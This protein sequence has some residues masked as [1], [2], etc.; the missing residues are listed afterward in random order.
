MTPETLP[1]LPASTFTVHKMVFIRRGE[2]ATTPRDPLCLLDSEEGK[3]V[4]LS[5]EDNFCISYDDDGLVKAQVYSVEEVTLPSWLSPE[6]WLASHSNWHFHWA[7]GMDP[8]WPE[9][10]QRGLMTLSALACY[11]LSGLIRATPR[12]DFKASLK[13]QLT[14]WLDLKPELREFQHPLSMRQM[15]CLYGYGKHDDAKR[16]ETQVY[17]SLRGKMDLGCGEF[18]PP[19][20]K[21]KKSRAKKATLPARRAPTRGAATLGAILPGIKY[22]EREDYLDRGRVHG[23][24]VNPFHEPVTRVG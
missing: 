15:E 8:T 22:L 2:N 12:G 3:K 6:E 23:F 4:D 21:V 17:L 16:A 10:W 13:A 5:A 9:Q 7:M 24:L 11:V 20:P 18:L 1:T 14:S 19:P